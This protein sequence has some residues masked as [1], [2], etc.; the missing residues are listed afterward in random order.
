[1]QACLPSLSCE[2]PCQPFDQRHASS[3]K[4]G[5]W[6]V[7][8]DEPGKLQTF[9]PVMSLADFP[10]IAAAAQHAKA[11]TLAYPKTSAII[12]REAGILCWGLMANA[13]VTFPLIVPSA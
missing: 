13:Q 9:M 1:M 12:I 2:R 5:G 6:W 8:Q 3:E 11:V 10:D 7:L 4:R